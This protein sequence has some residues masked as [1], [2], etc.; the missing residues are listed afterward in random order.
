MD[1]AEKHLAQQ[2]AKR[3]EE[4]ISSFKENFRIG[5][6]LNN[7]GIRKL[8]GVSPPTLF[9]V[10]FM[11][12]FEGYDFYRGIVTN[13]SLGFKKDAACDFLKNPGHNRRKFLLSLSSSVV[14]FFD[15]LTDEKR[16]KVLIFDDSAYD[17][18]RSE[19]VELLARIHDHNSG[20]SLKGFRMLTLG[21]S[22]GVNFLPPDFALLSSAEAAERVQ[23]ITKKPD[24]RT[25]GYKRRIEA[26]TKSHYETIR[27]AARSRDVN[28][29]DETARK[30]GCG[31]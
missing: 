19:A 5:T 4:R 25:C 15:Y 28:Y 7:S 31:L 16:V 23:G 10:I 1:I 13:P 3:L 12:P 22:D 26:M 18:C 27:D 6:L 30:K 21:R 8:R 17:R 9:T 24:K 29:P 20:R 11:L 14:R 2:E